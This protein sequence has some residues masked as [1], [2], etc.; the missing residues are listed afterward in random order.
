[1]IDLERLQAL[2]EKA[3]PGPWIATEPNSWGDDDDI[4]QS[5]LD[6]RGGSLTWDDHSGEV[7]KPEDALFIAEARQAV[8]ELI[9]TVK[10]LTRENGHLR[11]KYNEDMEQLRREH[12]G[13]MEVLQSRVEAVQYVIDHWRVQ[14][15]DALIRRIRR[16]LD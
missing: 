6:V 8:P 12:V 5:G 13:D 4:L 2:E 16:A 7:F 9:L 1:M 14:G 15:Y 10:R 11:A 3:T